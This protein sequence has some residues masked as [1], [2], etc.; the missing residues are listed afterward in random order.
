LLVEDSKGKAL[1]IGAFNFVAARKVFPAASLVLCYTII[2]ANK[3]SLSATYVALMIGMTMLGPLSV[4]H[5]TRGDDM[6]MKGWLI[7]MGSTLVS[8]KNPNHIKIHNL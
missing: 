7:F 8:S 2:L 3:A 4:L 1:A 5:T 6:K